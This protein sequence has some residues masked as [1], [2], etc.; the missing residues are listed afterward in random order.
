[1]NSGLHGLGLKQPT[2]SDTDQF[3]NNGEFVSSCSPT[4][5]A[6]TFMGD[7]VSLDN[8]AGGGVTISLWDASPSANKKLAFLFV[9]GGVWDVDGFQQRSGTGTQDVTFHDSSIN[10]DL[11]FITGINTDQENSVQQ[12]AVYWNRCIRWNK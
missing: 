9:K 8:A 12:H 10:P 11:V 1:M 6:I 3:T 5:G 7:V 2:T 4:T